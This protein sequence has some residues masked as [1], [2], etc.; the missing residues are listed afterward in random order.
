M[1]IADQIPP[2]H[3]IGGIGGVL[4]SL[5]TWHHNPFMRR[6][7]V[8][9]QPGR[10]RGRPLPG[11]PTVIAILERSYRPTKIIAV[12][13]EIGHRLVTPPVL[14]E[15]VTLPHLPRVLVPV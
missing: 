3:R 4:A 13:R 2:D 15:R 11:P 9:G 1:R 7:D 6:P 8:V 12:H 10:H 5:N 14:R